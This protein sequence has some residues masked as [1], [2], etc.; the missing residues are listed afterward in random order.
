MKYINIGKSNIKGAEI[1]LGCMRISELSKDD[2]EILI[3]TS[4]DEG[5]NFF[6]HEDIYSKG[7]S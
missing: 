2:T 6:A 7:E 1:A 4:L 3:K 5:I